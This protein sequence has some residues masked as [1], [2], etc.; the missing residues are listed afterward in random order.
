MSTSQEKDNRGQKKSSDETSA[1]GLVLPV[2]REP[3]SIQFEA[4]VQPSSFCI[5]A[6]AVKRE[7]QSRINRT[8]GQRS[9]TKPFTTSMQ[10][11]INRQNT[12]RISAI[13]AR[14]R[15]S[16][17]VR[18]PPSIPCSAAAPD[19][20]KVSIDQAACNCPWRVYIIATTGDKGIQEVVK[21]FQQ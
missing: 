6:N 3:Y 7:M 13:R 21:V 12:T 4:A 18:E 10:L 15:T 2:L 19:G 9:R 14:R 5:S 8:D 11:S 20:S 16:W 1:R 17:R